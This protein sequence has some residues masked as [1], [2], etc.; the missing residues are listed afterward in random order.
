MKRILILC[1]S[2]VLTSCGPKHPVPAYLDPHRL[3]E[4]RV[5]DALGRLTTNEKIAM[6]HA[7]SKFS[8]VTVGT[9]RAASLRFSHSG[10]D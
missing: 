5:E 7:Q 1:C 4:E 10:M 2:A 9:R 6:L 8:S 3:I